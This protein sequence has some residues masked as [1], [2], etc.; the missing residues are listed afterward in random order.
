MGRMTDKY[1][2][3]ALL[4]LATFIPCVSSALEYCPTQATARQGFVLTST[5]GRTRLEVQPSTD[6]MVSYSVV[7]GGKRALTPTYYRGF[8]LVRVVR[9]DGTTGTASY[10]FD[11]MKEPVPDVG[12][13][14]AFRLTLPASDGNSITVAVDNRIV[15]HESIAIGDCSFD[16]LV[17]E[18]QTTNADGS[19]QQR[20]ANFSP[21]L[22]MYVRMVMSIGNSPPTTTAYNRIEPLSP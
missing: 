20:R 4:G 22:R 2:I 1:R 14:K 11:Y 9:A 18:G 8:F 15:G 7:A 17:I 12:Y 21:L 13:H 10:D 19:V 6:D 5:D 16:T 3:A